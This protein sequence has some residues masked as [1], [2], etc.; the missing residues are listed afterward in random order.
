MM[1][2][3]SIYLHT[4]DV[5]VADRPH[6]FARK[7]STKITDYGLSPIILEKMKIKRTLS[8]MDKVNN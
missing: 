2:H 3:S 4:G 1:R 7:T 6:P 5:Q 8:A